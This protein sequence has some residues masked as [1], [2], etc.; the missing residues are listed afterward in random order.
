LTIR[1]RRNII[2]SFFM[3]KIIIFD[4]DGTLIT[5][6]LESAAYVKAW[7]KSFGIT[8]VS[9]DW[10]S[11]PS[12]NDEGIAQYILQRHFGRPAVPAEIKKYMDAYS[13]L[14][15]DIE[16]EFI[17]GAAAMLELLSSKRGTV[18]A[19]ATG[20]WERTA[21]IRLEKAALWRYFRCGAYAEQGTDKT[22]ILQKALER[23]R[24]SWPDIKGN[25][26]FV[27][28]GDQCAD[29]RAAEVHSI[30][31]IGI[32]KRVDTYLGFPA[33]YTCPDYLDLE[34]FIRKLDDLLEG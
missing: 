27:Y 30:P 25:G 18:L 26:S 10:G 14:L 24:Q 29:A 19:L 1:G 16:P 32:H 8:G 12:P 22:H 9:D 13:A 33:A 28:I 21:K 11:Y 20:N 31:F 23:C 34:G 6:R 5:D 15:M 7:E 3:K 4:I 2:K 17:P